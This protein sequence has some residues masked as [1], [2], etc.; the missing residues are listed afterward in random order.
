MYL[1]DILVWAENHTM[2]RERVK[3]VIGRLH[4]NGLAMNLD[5][6]IFAQP[7]IEYLG[8]LVSQ[9]GIT[10]LPRK[11]DIIVGF[12]TPNKPKAL[13]GFLGAVNYYRRC[14]PNVDGQ[15]PADILQPLYTAA[16]RKI[17][18]KTFSTIW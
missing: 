15:T 8:Y 9:E 16:T 11:V 1:D 5:K 18:G 7:R 14:L 2:H 3:E 13:L 4:A 10:P 6:C 17:L 12:P